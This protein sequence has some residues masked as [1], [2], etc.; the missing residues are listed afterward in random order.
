MGIFVKVSGKVR[1]F[2]I[3]MLLIKKFIIIINF[4]LLML[5]SNYIAIEILIFQGLIEFLE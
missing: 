2:D 4:I 1:K 5:F 3:S